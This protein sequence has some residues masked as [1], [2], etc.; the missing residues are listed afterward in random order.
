MVQT[1]N[2]DYSKG[3]LSSIRWTGERKLIRQQSPLYR[4]VQT[5]ITNGAFFNTNLSTRPYQKYS[6]YNFL[7][8][9]NKSDQTLFIITDTFRK[10][11]PA[12]TVLSFDEETVPA[13]R[14]VNI[15]NASGAD[16]TGEIEVLCQKIKSY[17]QIIKEKL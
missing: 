9:T 7:Q 12:S 16:A 8:V 17:R 6:P 5:D 15:Q 2:I 3:G 1:Q 11:I 4:F 13:Y 10:S 14:K